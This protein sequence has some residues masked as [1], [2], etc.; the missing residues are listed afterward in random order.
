MD[1]PSSM[2][3]S[4]SYIKPGHFT[5]SL[6]NYKQMFRNWN[7]ILAIRYSCFIGGLNHFV[8]WNVY[9]FLS[10]SHLHFLKNNKELGFANCLPTNNNGYWPYVSSLAGSFSKA[11]WDRIQYL[12]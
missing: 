11:I 8:K 10:I 5:H 4:D 1:V 3:E 9:L 7:Q 12:S 6:G 2:N